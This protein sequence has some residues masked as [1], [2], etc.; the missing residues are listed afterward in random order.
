MN[1][2]I[3]SIRQFVYLSDHMSKTPSPS[4]PSS[5]AQAP[6]EQTANSEPSFGW[7]AYAEKLNGRFAMVGF[8]A[9]LII[10]LVTRQDFVTWLGL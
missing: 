6:T 7:N 5:P 8:M 1:K 4:S 3:F 9:L 10:E 2:S